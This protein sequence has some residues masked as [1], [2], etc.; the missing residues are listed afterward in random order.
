MVIGVRVKTPI[1]SLWSGMAI[2]PIVGIYIPIIRIPHWRWDAPPAIKEFK[3][4]LIWF[5]KKNIHARTFWYNSIAHFICIL[6][7]CIYTS[8]YP[9]RERIHIPPNGKR[10]N[11]HLQE[12]FLICDRFLEGNDFWLD[13]FFHGK[14]WW[15]F[16][17][18]LWGIFQVFM[19][20][21]HVGFLENKP[22]RNG[23]LGADRSA[24]LEFWSPFPARER[25]VESQPAQ[26]LDFDGA[27]GGSVFWHTPKMSVFFWTYDLYSI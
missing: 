8:C 18:N 13:L 20:I 21:F 12:W 9:L 24:L 6:Y 19:G 26:E 17:R 1:G 2:N 25:L 10:T 15:V 23:Y 3:P 14:P 7:T 11:H 5:R 16:A 22:L 27:G 4:W